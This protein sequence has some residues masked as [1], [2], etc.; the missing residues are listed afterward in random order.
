MFLLQHWW[1]AGAK[2]LSLAACLLSIAPSMRDRLPT[3]I[4][5]LIA[6]NSA[7]ETGV[8]TAARTAR[9]GLRKTLP[10]A[11]LLRLGDYGVLVT[12]VV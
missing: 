5:S 6:T 9:C 3:S 12:R 7:T 4:L 8:I 10:L 1:R 2:A 11:G